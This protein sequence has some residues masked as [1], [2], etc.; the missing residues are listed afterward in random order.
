MEAYLLSCE[1]LKTTR[2]TGLDGR[3]QAIEK[4]ARHGEQV[5]MTHQQSAELSEPGVGWFGSRVKY[6]EFD[7]IES[8]RCAPE[9]K[10][11]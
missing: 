2:R 3:K 4:E 1:S 10:G 8:N 7:F 9:T 5:L 11:K 6:V